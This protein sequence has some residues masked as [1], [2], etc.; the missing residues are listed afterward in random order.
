MGASNVGWPEFDVQYINDP[1]FKKD[2]LA[3][4]RTHHGMVVDALVIKSLK[5]NCLATTIKSSIGDI[6]N[7]NEI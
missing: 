4:S 3:G 1:Q 5:Y 7:L 6:E 2:W